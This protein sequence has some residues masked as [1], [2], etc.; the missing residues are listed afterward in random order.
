MTAPRR[1][2]SPQGG[3]ISGPVARHPVNR[4]KSWCCSQLGTVAKLVHWARP[5]TVGR[6]VLSLIIRA[7][8]LVECTFPKINLAHGGGRGSTHVDIT[9]LS[10]RLGLLS[11]QDLDPSAHGRHQQTSSYSKWTTSTDVCPFA[12]RT[13]QLYLF[14]RKRVCVSVHQPGMHY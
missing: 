8:H 14:S 9:L 7:H 10:L 5:Q 4:Q 13:T 6:H 11:G 12:Q 2:T 1:R 3:Q